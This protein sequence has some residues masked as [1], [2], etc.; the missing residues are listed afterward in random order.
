MEAALAKP[1]LKF[2][3]VGACVLVFYVFLKLLSIISG[4]KIPA[5]FSTAFSVFLFGALF[6]NIHFAITE[7]PFGFIT[8]I[9][10][11]GIL[12]LR[13]QTNGRWL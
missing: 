1:L 5:N 8:V 4:G 12:W 10:I 6:L 13:K 9:I 11:G 2:A 3:L 7:E